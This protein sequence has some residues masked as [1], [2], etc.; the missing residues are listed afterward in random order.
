MLTSHRFSKRRHPPRAP[1]KLATT[2]KAQSNTTFEIPRQAV[3]KTLREP[4]QDATPPEQVKMEY[5]DQA[6]NPFIMHEKIGRATNYE[7]ADKGGQ[8]Q[9]CYT[10]KRAMYYRGREENDRKRKD[11]APEQTERKVKPAPSKGENNNGLRKEENRKEDLKNPGIEGIARTANDASPRIYEPTKQ[12]Q[13]IPMFSALPVMLPKNGPNQHTKSKE[14]NRNADEE[15]ADSQTGQTEKPRTPPQDSGVD[16]SPHNHLDTQRDRPNNK[17][18]VQSR[19][20]QQCHNDTIKLPVLGQQTEV[21]DKKPRQEQ[22]QYEHSDT[23]HRIFI[24]AN[25]RE[26]RM[27]GWELGQHRYSNPTYEYYVPA[28]PHEAKIDRYLSPPPRR[29]L[30]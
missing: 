7:E 22:G 29:N 30:D 8:G 11:Q 14:A 6:K 1:Q 12:V 13:L 19:K 17:P 27:E 26:A 28:N 21:Y 5:D 15:K 18:R 10:N 4:R 24:P 3:T 16:Q 25:P 23:S 20:K 9:P 2:K